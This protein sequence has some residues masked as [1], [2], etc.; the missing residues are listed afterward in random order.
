MPALTSVERSA[1]RPDGGAADEPLLVLLHIPK[2]AGMTLAAIL[3]N[4]YGDGFRGGVAESR[5]RPPERRMPNVFSRFDYVDARLRS[6]AANPGVHALSGHITF[7]FHDRLPGDARWLTVLREPVERTLSQYFF[8]VQPPPRRSGRAGAGFVPPWLPAPTPELSLEDALTERGYIP[9]N[10]Q[11]RMICGLV[12]PYDPLPAGALEQA[13][14]NLRERF[15]YVGTTERFD[16]FLA[17]LNLELGW[18][19]V[20]YRR[21]NVNPAGC[22]ATDLPAGTL[23]SSRSGT[24]STASCTPTQSSCWTRRLRGS[25]R[26]GG[27]G[28]GAQAGRPAPP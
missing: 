14:Q 27:R 13:K 2:T 1:A 20:A 16:E 12:S 24:R 21:S 18:P 6:I 9:D 11:T 7:G 15:A 22:G 23:A 5:G 4:H 26:A 28:G 3:Q 25:A 19:T 10:L 8:F 17:L